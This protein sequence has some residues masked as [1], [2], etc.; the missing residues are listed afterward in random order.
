MLVQ[1]RKVPLVYR[2]NC[3]KTETT[4][5]PIL[6]LEAPPAILSGCAN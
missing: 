1:Q 2:V 6:G 4:M 3:S 5:L